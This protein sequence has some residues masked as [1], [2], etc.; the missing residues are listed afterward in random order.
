MFWFWAKSSVHNPKWFCSKQIFQII[1][2]L[3]PPIQVCTSQYFL[4]ILCLLPLAFTN[5]L[6]KSKLDDENQNL[7]KKINWFALI[8][9]WLLSKGLWLLCAYGLEI[10][11]TQMP[12]SFERLV[13]VSVW[14]ASVNFFL[15]NIFIIRK[16]ISL[17]RINPFDSF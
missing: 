14:L 13:W 10:Q 15:C 11:S 3:P 1:F 7:N 17:N 12:Q 4:W 16:F 6:K 5:C 8:V 9:Y 2:L